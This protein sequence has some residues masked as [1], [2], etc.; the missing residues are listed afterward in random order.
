MVGAP[1]RNGVFAEAHD[2][3]EWVGNNGE[4]GAVYAFHKQNMSWVEWQ[5]LQAPDRN[6]SDAFGSALALTDSLLVVGAPGRQNGQGA[7]YCFRLLPT[8]QWQYESPLTQSGNSFGASLA[9]DGNTLAV[10]SP[11]GSGEVNIYVRNGLQ[12]ILVDQLDP[13]SSSPQRAFGFSLDLN[14]DTLCIG[15]PGLNDEGR[16][17]IYANGPGGWSLLQEL[18]AP[19]ATTGQG[20]G[21]S[22]MRLGDQIIVGEPNHGSAYVF[23][24]NGTNWIPFTTLRSGIANDF[25]GA[26]L[27]GDVL[28]GNLYI[29]AEGADNEAGKVYG[30]QRNNVG[31]WSE[32]HVLTESNPEPG[33]RFGH[34]L[35]NRDGEIFI[36]APLRSTQADRPNKTTGGAIHIEQAF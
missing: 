6:A 25:F 1:G 8:G 13:L 9:M 34:V 28:A 30:F 33:E 11:E 14:N 3:S 2:S 21:H 27:A 15:A 31:I 10:A 35:Q 16:L 17:F 22:V 18:S 12:W 26:S 36:G 23:W 20:F 29:G 7:A 5:R 32:T 24:N 19:D 4:M